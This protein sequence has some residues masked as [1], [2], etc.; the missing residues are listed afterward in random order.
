MGRLSALILAL[1]VATALLR[2]EFLFYLVYLCI[3][4]YVWGRWITP[5][6]LRRLSVWREFADHA[7]LGEEVPVR[8]H[9]RNRSRL[10]LPWLEVTE[11]AAFDLRAGNME[12][13]FVILLFDKPGKLARSGHVGSFPDIEK[14]AVGAECH[15]PRTAQT[16]IG[17]HTR[18]TSGRDTGD[19]VRN[20]SDV[21]GRRATAATHEV[22]PAAF[23]K[24]P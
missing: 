13:L 16:Q 21:F 11:S 23:G 17:W 18:R 1:V 22:D 15:R 12:R 7:F 3:G 6:S 10:P 5:W 20:G 19:R 4:L 9:V 14:I 24:L 2:V 8:V